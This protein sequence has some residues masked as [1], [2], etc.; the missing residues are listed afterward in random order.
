MKTIAALVGMLA[1]VAGCA[2]HV[3]ATSGDD[4]GAPKTCDFSYINVGDPTPT[5]DPAWV[6]AP[7]YTGPEAKEFSLRC[8]LDA[9]CLD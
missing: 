9:A 3:E 1:L 6:C 5:P 4:A 8:T 2:G 7:N